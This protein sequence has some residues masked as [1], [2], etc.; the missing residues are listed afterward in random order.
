MKLVN[1][2]NYKRKSCLSKNTGVVYGFGIYLTKH[3]LHGLFEEAKELNTNS[4]KIESEIRSIK[5]E[6]NKE[7][8]IIYWGKSNI[9]DGRI[10]DHLCGYQNYNL[11]LKEYQSLKDKKI[12]YSVLSIDKNTE[13]EKI[14]QKEYPPLLRTKKH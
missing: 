4:I 12:I 10:R 7:L 9:I 5:K 13:L 2:K 11:H 6:N 8:Y 1:D 14:L 3:E